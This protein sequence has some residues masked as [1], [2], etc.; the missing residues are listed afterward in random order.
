M[1]IDLGEHKSGFCVYDT[2]TETPVQHGYVTATEPE[3]ML[4]DLIAIAKSRRVK[5]LI[6]ELSNRHDPVT[7]KL[8]R[9]V[10]D[11]IKQLDI[12]TEIHTAAEWRQA[13]RFFSKR[14]ERDDYKR[15]A[16]NYVRKN[17]PEIY[18][19][20]MPDDE[21][22]AI[23]IAVAERIGYRTYNSMKD[24]RNEA[25]R[26]KKIFF[27]HEEEDEFEYDEPTEFRKLYR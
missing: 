24:R 13:L 15:M 3:K 11:A 23:C 6:V 14:A 5:Q 22:E 17:F 9:T 7:V 19:E 21:A 10:R 26:Q 25:A 18:R 16:L 12:P 4:N 1:T 20:D 2:D 27:K 8:K